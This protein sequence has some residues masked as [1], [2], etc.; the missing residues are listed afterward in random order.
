MRCNLCGSETHKNIVRFE[1]IAVVKCR[2]CGL[3]QMDPIKIGE[4]KDDYIELEVDEFIDYIESVRLPQFEAEMKDIV[5][6]VKTGRVLDIGCST[7]LFLSLARKHGFE[8]Y[9][10]EPSESMCKVAG[11]RHEGL[12]L[13]NT[14]FTK[15]LFRGIEFD[16]VT[17]WSV[18]EHIPD[19][20]RFLSECRAVLKKDGV[21]AV[22]VPNYSGLIPKLIIWAYKLSFGLISAPAKSLYEYHFVY[23]HFYHYTEK[24]LS[25]MMENTGFKVFQVKREN[26]INMG[27]FKKRIESSKR[28]NDLGWARN[29]LLR[30]MISV[31]LKISDILK[32]Q[33]E[34]VVFCKKI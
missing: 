28:K 33:D 3:V 21:L 18:L 5:K 30:A 13:H 11:C 31:V 22:R 32:L 17:V 19:P 20:K 15:E 24:T 4:C 23:K 10:V 1:D 12:N 25:R 16:L 9:G 34:I 6:V 7:G 2:E 26:S 29:P 27:N 14:E 8:A